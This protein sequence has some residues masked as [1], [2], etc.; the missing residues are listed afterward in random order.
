M[1]LDLKENRVAVS[2]HIHNVLKGNSHFCVISKNIIKRDHISK[3]NNLVNNVHIFQINK[4]SSVLTIYIY[5][6]TNNA[7]YY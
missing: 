5:K 7:N 6:F 1:R 4:Q 3:S 2:L